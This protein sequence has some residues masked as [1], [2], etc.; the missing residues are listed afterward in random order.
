MN[1]TGLLDDLNYMSLEDIKDYDIWHVYKPI[2]LEFMDY[3][4]KG[5]NIFLKSPFKP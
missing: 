2:K 3:V 5:M 4:V 1:H